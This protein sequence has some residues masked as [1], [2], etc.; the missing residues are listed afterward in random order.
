[1]Q[2]GVLDAAGAG[3][4]TPAV[5]R[6]W[7]EGRAPLAACSEALVSDDDWCTAVLARLLLLHARRGRLP[8]RELVGSPEGLEL[9]LAL[10]AWDAAEAAAPAAE[11]GGG[12]G[13]PPGATLA[14]AAAAQPA[15]WLAPARV[16]A[17]RLR[18]AELDGDR[19]GLLSPQDFSRCGRVG[20]LAAA[21]EHQLAVCDLLPPG[22]ADAP[23]RV[24]G[25]PRA[26][27]TT[28]DPSTL[29]SLAAAASRRAR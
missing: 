11:D 15:A 25:P 13:E 16:A 14:A 12:G 4:L 24:P 8:L 17:L 20:T 5:L 9:A 26:P 1:M 23:V 18:F 22:P 3:T 27:P 7:L 21:I 2:L 6:G 28:A 10:H 29:P 19:D